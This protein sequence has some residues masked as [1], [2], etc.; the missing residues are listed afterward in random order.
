L[1]FLIVVFLT[2]NSFGQCTKDV[3]NHLR[4]TAL[5][6]GVDSYENLNVLHNPVNDAIDM[7]SCLTNL[8]FAVRLET[9]V[10]LHQMDTA[11]TGW[12]STLPNFDIALFYFAGHGSEIEGTNYMYPVDGD[13]DSRGMVIKTAYSVKSLLDKM[14][15]RNHNVNIVLLDACRDSLSTRG[16]S[17]RLLRTGFANISSFQN[18]GVLIG[19]STAPGRRSGDGGTRNGYYTTAL[20]ENLDLP[21]KKLTDIFAKV[22]DATQVLSS[23]QQLP[24]ISS[25]LGD[26][27]NYCLLIDERSL[28]SSGKLT[29]TFYSQQLSS[30]KKKPMPP[31]ATWRHMAND[32]LQTGLTKIV[33]EINIIA[34]SVKDDFQPYSISSSPPKMGDT[35]AS[36]I[37]FG[38]RSSTFDSLYIIPLF[39]MKVTGDMFILTITSESDAHSV[40]SASRLQ[41]FFQYETDHL[42]DHSITDIQQLSNIDWVR[43]TEMIKG[44]FYS[45]LG[46]LNQ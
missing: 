20:L 27:N 7:D 33:Q 5:I 40:L 18:P 42:L 2:P 44:Y 8:H 32:A 13:A 35:A 37:N 9:N 16:P 26:H 17:K 31:I 39:T 34:D 30:F 22:N 4:R 14:Q 45:R 10:S 1:S 41:Q 12:L 15:A 43:F 11:I 19:F 46:F 36:S 29:D 23:Y 28:E 25:S 38:I 3:V 24:F 6:I 21:N